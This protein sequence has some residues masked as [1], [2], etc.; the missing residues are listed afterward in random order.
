MQRNGDKAH[1]DSPTQR[2]FV[3][4]RK[5]TCF[6][7]LILNLLASNTFGVV[8]PAGRAIIRTKY[9]MSQMKLA[10]KGR[11]I[12]FLDQRTS[13]LKMLEVKTGQ[14]YDVSERPV[15]SFFFSPDGFRLFYSESFLNAE[16]KPET[17]LRS[18]DCGMKKSQLLESYAE[19]MGLLTFDPRDRQISLFSVGGI[20]VKKLKY[21]E[22]RLAN[23]QKLQEPK[24]GRYVVT[25]K[26]VLWIHQDLGKQVLI[27]GDNSSINSFEISPDGRRIAWATRDNWIYV[28]EAGADGVK[29]T[30]GL[31]PTWHPEHPILMV[32]GARMVGNVA[33]SYDLQL[34]NL[35]GERKFVTNTQFSSERWPAW[36][37]DGNRLLFTRAKTTDIYEI[38]L[39]GLKFN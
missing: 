4:A 5:A 16:E 23:W 10:P 6:G 7:L 27:Q 13:E 15:Q 39:S 21:P 29:L 37:F 20:K 18:F 31:D 36:T 22:S 2:S 3:L 26:G 32:A 12:A 34:V 9:G 19:Q 25:P 14:V 35:K 11:F 8:Q 17:H 30:R 1:E 38:S 24:K 33:T 28:S